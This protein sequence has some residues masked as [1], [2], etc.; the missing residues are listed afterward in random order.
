[1]DR[2]ELQANV[3]L[4]AWKQ[5]ILSICPQWNFED[6]ELQSLDQ[7]TQRFWGFAANPTFHLTG[8]SPIYAEKFIRCRLAEEMA[9]AKQHDRPWFCKVW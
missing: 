8:Q 3:K 4:P 5:V 1:M 2:G 9:A 6:G 7:Q